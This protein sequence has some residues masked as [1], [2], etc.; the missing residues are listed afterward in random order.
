MKTIIAGSRDFVSDHWLKTVAFAVATL[1]DATGKQVSEVVCGG[2]PGI[3][4]KGALWAKAND[5]PVKV[6]EAEWTRLGKK[7]GP[8]RNQQMAKYADALILVWDGES[9]GSRSMLA[10]SEAAGIVTLNLTFENP[11]NR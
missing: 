5:I 3:D 6:F 11:E 9:R 1:Q 2:A 4:N 8:V 7:A 10:C